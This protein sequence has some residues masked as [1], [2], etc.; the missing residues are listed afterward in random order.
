VKTCSYCSKPNITT[1]PYGPGKRLICID[2]A[3]A[4]PELWAIACMYEIKANEKRRG[5]LSPIDVIKALFPKIE[6]ITITRDTAGD[7]NDMA[8]PCDCPECKRQ[9]ASAN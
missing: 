8:A 5:S 2:C 1:R 4:D 9:Q 7:C 3:A 6:V